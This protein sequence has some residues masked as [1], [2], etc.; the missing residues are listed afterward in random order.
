MAY[1]MTEKR[2]D[3]GVRGTCAEF[4]HG[5]LSAIPSLVERLVFV[6]SFKDPNTGKYQE[7][8]LALKFGAREVDRVLNQEH[9]AAFETWLTLRMPQQ[10]LELERY[11]ANDGKNP[12][13][14]LREWLNDKSYEQLIPRGAPQIQRQGFLTDLDTM[15]STRWTQESDI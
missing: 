4:V 9:M 7:P 12:R 8:F 10:A 15:R 14:V 2:N 3:A 11:C 6:A 13:S 1:Q 5:S